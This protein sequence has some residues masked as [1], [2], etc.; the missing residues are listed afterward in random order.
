MRRPLPERGRGRG[1]T[2]LRR[3]GAMGHDSA[4]LNS[5][6]T[7]SC[8]APPPTALGPCFDSGWKCRG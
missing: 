7:F 5:P 1:Q 3:G 6:K 8:L 4:P 2:V